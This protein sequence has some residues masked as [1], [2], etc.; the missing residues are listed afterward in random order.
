MSLKN[1]PS[2]YQR[3]D[4]SPHNFSLNS[5]QN[6]QEM[7]ENLDM[8]SDNPTIL[9]RGSRRSGDRN[10]INST[11]YH[12]IQF[13]H[14]TDNSSNI[15]SD[16]VQPHRTNNINNPITHKSFKPSAGGNAASKKLNFNK[17]NSS[18]KWIVYLLL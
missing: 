17:R 14:E 12:S 13:I 16:H 8:M 6:Q 5:D 4:G 18:I 7:I 1:V 2:D 11:G 10:S 3:L 9:V 15:N